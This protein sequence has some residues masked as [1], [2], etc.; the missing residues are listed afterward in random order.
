MDTQ[1]GSAANYGR[2]GADA[3]DIE[4]KNSYADFNVGSVNFLVG[5]QNFTLARGFIND[6]DIAGLKAIWKVNDGLSLVFAYEKLLEGGAGRHANENDVET[7]ILTPIISLSKDITI[8][9]YYVFL[10]SQD[11][12]LMPAGTG[13]TTNLLDNVNAH[14]LGAD[15][16]AKMGPASVWLTGIMQF[17]D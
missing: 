7:Y 10:H 15:F 11:A 4:I 16:D 9:P 1:W 13:T 17:G 8:K 5:I 6:D 2:V 14:V 3:K 12:L